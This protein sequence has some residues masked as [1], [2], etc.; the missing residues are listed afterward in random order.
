[1]Y[2][3]LSSKGPLSDKRLSETQDCSSIQTSFGTTL[4][5][6]KRNAVR[7]IQMSEAT[8]ASVQRFKTFQTYWSHSKSRNVSIGN[9][10]RLECSFS[11]RMPSEGV[12]VI[13]IS[14]LSTWM[15]TIF[16]IIIVIKYQR[17]LP[18]PSQ[19]S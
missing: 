4:I 1:M 2:R 11:G 6:I 14:Q 16:M 18:T 13:G 10:I 7:L 15:V 12:P 3:L 5:R 17:L 19:S 9:V 8:A